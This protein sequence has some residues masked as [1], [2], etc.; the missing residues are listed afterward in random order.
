MVFH[1]LCAPVISPA[2]LQQLDTKITVN[3]ASQAGRDDFVPVQL[4]SDQDGWKSRPLLGKSGLMS[5][6]A[7][8][9]GYVHIAYEKQGL[10]AGDKVQVT[11][12]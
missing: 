2:A 3:V 8:A 11:L 12:F 7:Q 1:I 6:L 10:R 4:I 5:I 9:D